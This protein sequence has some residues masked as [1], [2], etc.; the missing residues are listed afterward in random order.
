MLLYYKLR[1]SRY[2]LTS[3]NGEKNKKKYFNGIEDS[4]PRRLMFLPATYLSASRHS[5]AEK[6]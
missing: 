2:G 1:E 5:C 4:F 6:E 3:R